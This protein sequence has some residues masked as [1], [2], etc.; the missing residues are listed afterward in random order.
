MNGMTELFQDNQTLFIELS[1]GGDIHV[2]IIGSG[3]RT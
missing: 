2:A 3:Q 1:T